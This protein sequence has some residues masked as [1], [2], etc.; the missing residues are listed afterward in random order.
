M[1]NE[2]IFINN[3]HY[4]DHEGTV[5]GLVTISFHSFQLQLRT[6]YVV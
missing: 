3:T 2:L 1:N 4:L 6:V 5:C